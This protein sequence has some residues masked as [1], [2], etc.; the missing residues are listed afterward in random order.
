[1]KAAKAKAGED[2]VRL[3]IPSATILRPSVVFGPEDQFFNK[4]AA[5]AVATPVMPLIRGAAR[6]QPVFVADVARAAAAALHDP[7]TAGATYELGGPSVYTLR[8]LTE[9]TLAEIGRPRPLLDIPDGIAGLLGLAGDALAALRGPLPMLPA[10]PI[11]RD[12]I[13]LLETDNVVA[14]GAL[15]FADLGIAPMALEPII[16]T[17]LYRYRKGGQ[18][19]DLVEPEALRAAP[20]A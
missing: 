12:Q 19:A 15:D 4:I 13:A 16:P 2:A 9:L 11:T 18:Y 6:L 14:P 17:Y 20:I 7:E 8:Q 3:A 10:P 1:M 5:M